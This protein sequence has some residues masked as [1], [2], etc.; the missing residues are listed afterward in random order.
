MLPPLS[1]SE[2]LTAWGIIA[3]QISYPR[4][5]GVHM[6][7]RHP[8][9]SEISGPRWRS[10]MKSHHS[11]TLRSARSERSQGHVLSPRNRWGKAWKAAVGH[12]CRFFQG[13]SIIWKIGKRGRTIQKIAKFLSCW[14]P[15]RN[16]CCSF[17]HVCSSPVSVYLS[18]YITSYHRNYRCGVKYLL[19][20]PVL[21][22]SC[23]S[24]LSSSLEVGMTLAFELS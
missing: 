20:L 3:W 13:R 17:I 18:G 7:R 24:I 1:T 12:R 8:F 6:T 10:H 14:V 9:W 23:F 19:W 11:L 16:V 2:S 21:I 5:L 22:Y 4:A 15:L